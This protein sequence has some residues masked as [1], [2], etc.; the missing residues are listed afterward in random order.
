MTTKTR[1]R[2]RPTDYR[3]EYIKI[4]L[5]LG[6]Q[7]KTIACI[8]AEIGVAKS[9]VQDWAEAHIDF[10]VAMK[11]SKA[12]AERWLVDRA[13]QRCDG[14]S[15]GSDN[16]IKWML[17]AAHGWRDRSDEAPAVSTTNVDINFNDVK[18]DLNGDT[19]P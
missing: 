8:A 10:G 2:G 18:P 17:A 1:P 4:A 13:L 9:T 11:Q 16:M 5:D 19:V 12:S 15:N 7:G 6:K 3:K 14:T